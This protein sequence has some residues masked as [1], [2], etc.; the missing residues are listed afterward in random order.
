MPK[1]GF[2]SYCC[3]NFAQYLHVLVDGKY[4]LMDNLYKS[5][6]K[7]TYLFILGL[8]WPNKNIWKSIN[9]KKGI[10]LFTGTD[11]LQLSKMEESNRNNLLN[12]LKRKNIIFSSEAPVIQEKIKKDF[13]L[14][15]DVIYLPSAFN[16]PYSNFSFPEKDPI[17]LPKN[18]FNIGCYFPVGEKHRE[19]Y[20]YNLILSVAKKSP[21]MNFHFYG[22]NGCPPISEGENEGCDNIIYY[23]NTIDDLPSFIS[24]M[25]C[26]LR[27]TI[28]DTYCMGGI[29]YN[30][31]GRWF[32]N[33]HEMP[34]CDKTPLNSNENDIINILQEIKNRE[35]CNIDGMNYYKKN[36]SV[37]NFNLRI[38]ELLEL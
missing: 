18:K 37:E 1:I 8:Y 30:L 23:K 14:N 19:H 4:L 32:V 3:V 27:I 16:K 26:G 20:N 24:K 34:Y 17:P 2:A 31:A 13:N 11:L 22:L 28:H 36:H 9:C 25:N 5:F 10:L 12:I 6:Y 35:I 38:K 33:N 7:N 29:E 21:D 15:T